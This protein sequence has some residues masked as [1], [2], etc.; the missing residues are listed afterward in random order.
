MPG[1][2]VRAV[3]QLQPLAVAYVALVLINT[4]RRIELLEREAK[5]SDRAGLI[6]THDQSIAL[7]ADRI[8]ILRDGALTE[9]PERVLYKELI[10]AAQQA[11]HQSTTI[12]N[13]ME[14]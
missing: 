14:D 11:N 5:A 7:R 1:V 6:A 9:D 4:R 8:Y 10:G 12:T 13:G 2:S 3:S